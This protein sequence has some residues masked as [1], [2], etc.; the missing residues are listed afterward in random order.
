[1]EK[2]DVI[3]RLHDFGYEYDEEHDSF[4]LDMA[5]SKVTWSVLNK[6]NCYS[7]PD[8]LANIAL[9]M[10]CAEFLLLMKN[11]GR[12]TDKLPQKFRVL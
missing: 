2:N 6:T 9:D 7:I 5:M 1:M 3:K 12:L 4:S 11:F 10:A 8:G